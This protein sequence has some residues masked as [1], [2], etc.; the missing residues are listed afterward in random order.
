MVIFDDFD[1]IVLAMVETDYSLFQRDYFTDSDQNHNK[2]RSHAT[3]ASLHTATVGNNPL[4]LSLLY[5]ISM[6]YERLS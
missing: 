5:A 6:K 4:P 3:V 2:H 1:C